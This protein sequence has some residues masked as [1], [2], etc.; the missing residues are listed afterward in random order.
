MAAAQLCKA[1]A[2]VVAYQSALIISDAI[3]S[4]LDDPAINKVLV[5][6]NSPG[7]NTQAAIAHLDRVRYLEC[8]GNVGFGRAVNSARAHVESEFVVLAN[9]DAQ[10]RHSAVS[11]AID[12]L[13]ARPCTAVVGPRM[14]HPDGTL[15]RNSQHRLTLRR[16][17]AEAL[18]WPK[19]WRVARAASEHHSAH[20]SEYVI[21]SFVV[22]RRSAMDDVDWFDE[23][24]FL[25][26]EDQDICR[27]LR[28]T[29][30]EIWYVPVGEVVHEGGHSWR[31]LDDR[32]RESFRL[33]R[34][35]ELKANSGR[36]SV[37]L[38]SILERLS[39]LRS[40]K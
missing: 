25:F 30:W 12:F 23:T 9:P 39:G 2:I 10:Q 18:G 19:A 40:G 26:G 8:G 28:A 22:C 11:G 37:L 17:I 24:I 36:M 35:R 14:V 15:Y 7:D 21:G 13:T 20:R 6:N 33:A 4:L 29:G 27:R 32:A 16:M 31:Q 34:R 1:D 5:V 38:Y 3:T